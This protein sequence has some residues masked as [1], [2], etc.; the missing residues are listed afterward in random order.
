MSTYS[1]IT[2]Q[3]DMTK[4]NHSLGQQTKISIT[5]KKKSASFTC[6]YD[7]LNFTFYN[8]NHDFSPR[9]TCDSLTGSLRG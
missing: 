3:P 5:L 8:S 9:V 1:N 6:F 7:I 4:Q 2:E